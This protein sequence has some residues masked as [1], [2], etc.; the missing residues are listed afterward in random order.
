MLLQFAL[1]VF[2]V[3]DQHFLYVLGIW[4]LGASVWLATA[5]CL[6]ILHLVPFKR[7]VTS[8]IQF[9]VGVRDLE[10]AMAAVKRPQFVRFGR[11]L[12]GTG[13]GCATSIG[14]RSWKPGTSMHSMHL[15]GTFRVQLQQ[16]TIFIG[17]IGEWH[18]FRG[19]VH[20]FWIEHMLVQQGL[21]R[22]GGPC[23]RWS[24]MIL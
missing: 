14:P 19:V 13:N 8:S 15:Y 20:I 17:T 4:P 24:R 23:R 11:T 5:K 6:D 12:R 22:P 2:C 21:E 18:H 7:I 3:S 16:F 10:I 1:L 9:S